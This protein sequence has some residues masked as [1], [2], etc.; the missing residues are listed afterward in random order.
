M[1]KTLA[2]AA[3]ALAVVS[4]GVML[5]GPRPA[6]GQDMPLRDFV[7][8]GETWKLLGAGR[9]PA[10][11]FK[12]TVL[13][14]PVLGG[15]AFN[16]GGPGPGG[17]AFGGNGFGGQP[18]GFSGQPASFRGFGGQ[19][20]PLGFG[21]SPPLPDGRPAAFALDL[22]G[23][24]YTVEA[25]ADNPPAAAVLTPDRMTL[26][27][28][29]TKPDT[30]VWAFAVRPAG[31]PLTGSRY[32]QLRT[33]ARQTG[34]AV[35]SLT[36]DAAGRIYAGT[37]DGVQVFDPTGRLCG[38]LPLPAKGSADLL[39]WEGDEQDRLILWMGDLKYARKMGTTGG[40]PK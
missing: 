39:A 32:A 33:A 30:H 26:Y 10:S 3:A 34:T 37:S 23:T 22:A 14:Q 15:T 11:P 2:R 38:V 4:V 9:R 1:T 12:L 24:A 35:T 13:G 25:P 29:L 21:G 19:P 27:V 17:A 20:I 5:V 6:A 18:G 31:A 8:D 36:T 7:P 16:G 40:P 28:G